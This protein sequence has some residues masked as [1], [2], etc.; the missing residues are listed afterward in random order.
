MRIGGLATGMDTEQ[1]VDKLMAAER[2]PLDRMEQDKTK[3][4]WKRDGFRDINKALLE[5][6][7][8]M[9]DMKMSKTYNTKTVSS[10]QENAVTA[11]A[12]TST[13][14]GTYSINVEKLATSAINV[15]TKKLG[16]EENKFNPNEPL[17]DQTEVQL[18]DPIRFST[19]NE[20][21]KKQ[22]HQIN[23]DD[24]DT[25]NDILKKINDD[26]DIPV[27]A[28]YDAQSD[29]VLMETTRTGQYRQK[30]YDGD[31]E[32]KVPEIVFE[33]DEPFFTDILK[34]DMS[35]ET[36]GTNAV[37]QYNNSGI[38]MESKTNSY[39]LNGVNFEFKNV[40]EENAHLTVTND[41][42][43]SFESIME[44]IDKY[45]EVVDTL[46]ESQRE[47]R[48]RDFPP[49]TEAQKKEM[50]ED[51]IEKWEEKAQSGILKGEAAIKDGMFAMRQSWYANVETGGAF[52]SLTEIGITTSKSY[53]DGGKL[54]VNEDDLRSALR[55]DP[56][57]V[58]KL[59]SNSEEGA[60]RGLVNRLEDAVEGTMRKIEQRAGKSTSTLENYTIGKRM[61]DL[62]NRI[63][64]FEERLTQVETRYWNQFTAME[65]AISRM[66]QQSEQLLAQ[67]GGGM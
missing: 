10:S 13:S 7:N 45:N 9:L 14:N 57:S 55:E 12:L 30:E 8:M 17:K 43:S 61:K 59:F 20:E 49:L 64:A 25:L 56:G 38:D 16:T 32:I 47:E 40:T 11:T 54:A 6:D 3:L 4:T 15:S 50:S 1:L 53:L 52:S 51:E 34:M 23:V 58:Q 31:K 44:F 28:F 39:E 36:G 27:R 42:E 41:V 24:G 46:N 60:S 26:D 19:Y 48:F 22:E 37:F 62:N 67:F 5:L 29:K 2:M 33:K 65:K 18:K 66:N 21:G 35:K 63:S